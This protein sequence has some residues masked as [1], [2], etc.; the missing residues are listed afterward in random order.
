MQVHTAHYA[1]QFIFIANSVHT[2]VVDK[3]LA[4][5][6]HVKEVSLRA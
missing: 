6:I 3:I 1:W 2:I 4:L 5:S